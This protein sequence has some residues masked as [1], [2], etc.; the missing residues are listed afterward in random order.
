L[1]H[2]SRR[3]RGVLCAQVAGRCT[4]R[5]STAAF[6]RVQV[7][8]ESQGA[9]VAFR[10]CRLASVRATRFAGP[11]ARGFRSLNAPQVRGGK[12]RL[13]GPPPAPPMDYL[14]KAPSREP[15][16]GGDYPPFRLLSIEICRKANFITSAGLPGDDTLRQKW[17]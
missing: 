3:L 17:L 13:E 10:D 1:R 8:H 12:P 6:S 5:R 7:A 9:P 11:S 16:W 4:P 2:A 15:G 14:R